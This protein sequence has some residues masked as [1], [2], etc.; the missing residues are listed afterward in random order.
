MEWCVSHCYLEFGTKQD[1]KWLGVHQ[2][3]A[4]THDLGAIG[5]QPHGGHEIMNVRMIAQIARP[6]L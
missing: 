2:E 1:R 5:D 6:G 4:D 3:A